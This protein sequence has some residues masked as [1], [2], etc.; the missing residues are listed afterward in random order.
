MKIPLV[1]LKAQYQDIKENINRSINLSLKEAN[2]IG[3]NEVKEFEK[4]F[5]KFNNSKFCVGVG[6]GTD[7]LVVCLM[8]LGINVGDEV[9][10]PTHTFISTSEAVR[11][12]GA[13]PVMIDIEEET[14][15]IDTNLVERNINKKTK[16]IIPVHLYGRPAEL[17][18]L[19]KISN[20]YSIPIISDAAQ[21]HN[22]KINKKDI[23]SF[24]LATC[25][26]FYPGKN[27]GAYGDGG[28]IISNNKKFIDK[29]RM[30][31]NHGRETKYLHDIN[32]I[33]S[34]LD[35][36]QASILSVKLKFLI[37]WTNRRIK[38]AKKYN[39]LLKKVKFVRL[40]IL[41]DNE[42]HVFHLYVIRVHK[43]L[44]DPL[45]DFLHKNNIGAG[46]H[47][48]VPLHLQPCNK[49]LKYS[50]G[51]FPISEKIS[52]EIISLPIYPELSNK[53]I[54]KISKKIIDFFNDSKK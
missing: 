18:K 34:R 45:L 54:I 53:M 10:V 27:L 15:N 3:G 39:S 48:P 16:A 37:R 43:D 8:A 32:G 30:I 28:A 13:K 25:F 31:S 7:A 1:D 14:F 2:F 21:A 11:I 50:K 9:I 41:P 33:N 46:I 19:N 44:R 12:V 40:P 38:I 36:I 35:A 20:K 17:I 51:S 49:D 22:S 24:C 26:S 47:Y 6:N 29:V 5:A 42:R 52:S 23:A 4:K